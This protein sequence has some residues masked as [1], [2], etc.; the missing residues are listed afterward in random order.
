MNGH[1]FP[2]FILMQPYGVCVYAYEFI[3]IHTVNGRWALNA[4][5]LSIDEDGHIFLLAAS[6][7]SFFGRGE[8]SFVL[9]HNF[10]VANGLR[11]SRPAQRSVA[12]SAGSNRGFGFASNFRL[13]I[14]L[15]N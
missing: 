6:F 12:G 5:L 4:L 9:S 11:F 8:F 15:E 2:H 1:A 7:L 3:D 14:S 13:I 10:P